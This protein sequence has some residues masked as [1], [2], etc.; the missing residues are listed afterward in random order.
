MKKIITSILAIFGSSCSEQPK[1]DV[2]SMTLW[3]DDYLMIEIMSNQNL[4][5]AKNETARINNFGK[6]HFDGNGFTAV[7]EIR[8]K[9]KATKELNIETK[10]FTELFD[11]LKIEK[12]P[13]LFYQR[14]GEP[15]SIEDSKTLVYGKSNTG[16]FIE[17]ENGIIENIW[18]NTYDWGN[19]Q[20]TKINLALKEIGDNFEMIMV[21]WFKGEIIDLK[22]QEEI[23]KYFE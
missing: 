21:D 6:E 11:K 16:V 5:F 22:S 19:L 23:D 4:E 20:E 17:Q 3:E 10:R 14:G 1:D 7:T 13:K 8:K 18:F 2:Q 9:K 15:K 12:Y